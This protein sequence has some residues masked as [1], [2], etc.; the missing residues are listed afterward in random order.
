MIRTIDLPSQDRAIV[1]T[2]LRNLLPPETTAWVFGSRATGGARR[3]SDLD[4]AFRSA[5]QLTPDTVSRLRDALSESDLTI[6][7]DLVDLATVDPAFR[8]LIEHQMLALPL[9]PD[10]I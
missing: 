5:E 1:Q 6:K 3:Y 2:I 10:P 4:L 8:R 7:V 9:R